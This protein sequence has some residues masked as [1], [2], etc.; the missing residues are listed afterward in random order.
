MNVSQKL[1]TIPLY[2]LEG[3]LDE[4]IAYLKTLQNRYADK[5][6]C[7]ELRDCKYDDKQEYILSWDRPENKEE[8][9][10]R[11]NKD[12]AAKQY[13]RHEYERLKKEFEAT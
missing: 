9:T 12:L 7:L 3:Q 5:I 6:T 2:K 13:R 1:M 10:Q 11:E 8:I 4:V